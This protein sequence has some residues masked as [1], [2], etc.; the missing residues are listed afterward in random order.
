MFSNEST[1][2]LY[3]LLQGMRTWLF[4]VPAATATLRVWLRDGPSGFESFREDHSA[5]DAVHPEER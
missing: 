1:T 4:P 3:S 5:A 2:T